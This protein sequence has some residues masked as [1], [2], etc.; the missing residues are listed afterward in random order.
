MNYY[1]TKITESENGYYVYFVSLFDDEELTMETFEHFVA[2]TPQ[3]PISQYLVTCDFDNMKVEKVAINPVDVINKTLPQDS[4]CMNV[5]NDFVSH[6]P[7]PKAKREPKK[8]ADKP[9]K[10]PKPVKP[11]GKQSKVQIS[12]EPVTVNMN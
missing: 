11:K 1:T 4:K 12:T 8:K 5:S 7:L 2:N 6:I 9:A 3:N 10:E